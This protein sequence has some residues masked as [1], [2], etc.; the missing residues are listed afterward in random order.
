MREGGVTALSSVLSQLPNDFL[1]ESELHFITMFFC[2]RL[3]D[4]H[5]IIPV[6]LRGILAIVCKYFYIF[7]IIQ[8]LSISYIFYN[9]F[10]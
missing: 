3:K 8:L 4:H 9:L 2:D 1:N 7:E 10:F 5:S 6:V